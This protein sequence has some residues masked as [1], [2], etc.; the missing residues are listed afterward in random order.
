[1]IIRKSS[2]FQELDKVEEEVRRVLSLE[3][4]RR[5]DLVK[6]IEKDVGMFHYVCQ[7]YA[8]TEVRVQQFINNYAMIILLLCKILCH[9]KSLTPSKSMPKAKPPYV[10]TGTHEHIRVKD[11]LTKKQ[12]VF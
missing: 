9:F 10:R 4:K 11:I 6:K 7:I 12:H 1:M 5:K 2:F 3:F 8:H